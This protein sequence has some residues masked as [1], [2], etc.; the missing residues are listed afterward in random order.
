MTEEQMANLGKRFFRVLGAEQTGSGLGWSIVRRVAQAHSA[1][2]T[3][4]RSELLG[5]LDVGVQ[6]RH[7]STANT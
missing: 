4:M 3:V 2:L 7:P 1:D 5:G 6:W